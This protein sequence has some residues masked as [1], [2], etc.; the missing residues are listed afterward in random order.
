MN[1]AVITNSPV[2]SVVVSAIT[3]DGVGTATFDPTMAYRYR[4]SRVWDANSPR[5]SFVML[6]PSTADEV[7]LDNSV[8]RCLRFAHGWGFGAIEVVNLFAVRSTDPRELYRCDDPIGQGNDDA[9]LAAAQ[10]AQLVVAAWGAHGAHLARGEHVAKMLAE[11]GIELHALHLTRDGTPGHP[12]Y[13]PKS[14]KPFRYR[15]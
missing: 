10:A 13:L 2:G 8:R 11:S 6:N 12:L 3:A 9:I 4:L 15:A 5:C 1:D 7:K 14:S